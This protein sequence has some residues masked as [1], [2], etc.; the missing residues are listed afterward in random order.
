MFLENKYTKWYFQII[1]NPD[2]SGYT[3]KHHIIPRCMGGSNNESNLARISA[4]QH[5]VCHLLL[6][7]MVVSPLFRSK[8]SYAMK[9]MLLQRTSDGKRYIP[10]SSKIFALCRTA[11]KGI[12]KSKE[13]K[14]K[15]SDA[16]RGI[17]L[18]PLSHDHRVNLSKALKGKPLASETCL[19]ISQSLKGKKTP[20][21]GKKHS[22]K[23]LLLMSLSQQARVRKPA[24]K[25]S[26]KAVENNRAAQ[27]K[28]IYTLKSPDG[29]TFKIVNIKQF[30]FENG[31][32]IG[33]FND[34]LKC[35]GKTF[36]DDKRLKNKNIIGWTYISR[37]CQ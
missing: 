24:A 9:C 7:K 14:Q 29:S 12:P 19:K 2:V 25:H 28:F 33:P 20:F 27:L 8:M 30:C 26:P 17:K 1:A 13:A 23:S 34:G 35:I 37:E 32:S 3:E 6:P 36:K 11:H 16:K 5:F 22:D 21:N 18:G 15:M 4:R 10:K 31:L